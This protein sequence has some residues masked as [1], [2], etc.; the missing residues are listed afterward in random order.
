M[1]SLVNQLLYFFI[2]YILFCIVVKSGKLNDNNSLIAMSGIIFFVLAYAIFNLLDGTSIG[3][4]DNS[5]QSTGASK[6]EPFFFE[7]SPEKLCDGGEYLRSS[8]PEKQKLCAQF[9][10]EQL[11]NFECKPGEYHGR[12]ALNRGYNGNY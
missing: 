8:S 2:I 12:P 7:V 4:C 10:T 6:N 5:C 9:S 11:A 3:L 1:S